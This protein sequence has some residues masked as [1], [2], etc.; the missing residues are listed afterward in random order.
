MDILDIL[1]DGEEIHQDSR[2]GPSDWATVQRD[3]ES[4]QYG[5]LFGHKTH[6]GRRLINIDAAEKYS[7]LKSALTKRVLKRNLSNVL[8]FHHNIKQRIALAKRQTEIVNRIP[9]I[10]HHSDDNIPYTNSRVVR[11][12]MY[13]HNRYKPEKFVCRHRI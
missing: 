2:T 3:S 9:G 8:Q 10:S 7:V 13:L 6:R 1:N 4:R 11:F 5:W 12:R